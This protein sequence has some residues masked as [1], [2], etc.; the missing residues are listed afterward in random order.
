[1]AFLPT[2][3][4]SVGPPWA[5]LPR[6]LQAWALETFGSKMLTLMLE[7]SA[8]V[9]ACIRGK[10]HECKQ[11]ATFHVKHLRLTASRKYA[12]S[13]ITSRGGVI[14]HRFPMKEAFSW[15]LEATSGL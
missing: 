11:H 13:C 8:T 4:S 2:P 3:S 14:T 6:H 10:P 5:V 7:N 12:P 15:T 1:M 9:K